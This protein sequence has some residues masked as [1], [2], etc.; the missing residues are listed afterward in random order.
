MAVNLG[1]AILG[2]L[3]GAV[4]G[5]LGGPM[6]DMLNQTRQVFEQQ[7]RFQTELTAIQQSGQAT[8]DAAKAQ[9]R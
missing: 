8:V 5:A 3:S 9:P 7:M 6:G 2:G 1:G 4:N